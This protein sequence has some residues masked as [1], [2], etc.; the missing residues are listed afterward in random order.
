MLNRPH[1]RGHI[2]KEQA[3]RVVLL[4]LEIEGALVQVSERVGKVVRLRVSIEEA[5]ASK[6]QL[7][8]GG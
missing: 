3:V 5:V 7:K 2:T 1:F 6:G 8:C 4:R